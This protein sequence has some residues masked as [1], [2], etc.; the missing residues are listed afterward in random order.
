MSGKKSAVPDLVG[1]L[2]YRVTSLIWSR[3][4]KKLFGRVSWLLVD[5]TVTD[6]T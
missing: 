5:N 6:G 4:F 3:S 1:L 2:V